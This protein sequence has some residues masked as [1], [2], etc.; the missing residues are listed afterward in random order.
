M[1]VC[2]TGPGGPG[3]SPSLVTAS[4][5]PPPG[6]VRRTGGGYSQKV[7]NFVIGLFA[8]QLLGGAYLFGYTLSAGRRDSTAHATRLPSAV[9][10]SHMLLGG[11]STA[12]WIGWVVSDER[13]FAWASFVSVALGVLLGTVMGLRTVT[14]PP[15]VDVP[16]NP[17]PRTPPDPADVRV[18][19]K[20]IPGVALLGHGGLGVTLLLL[21]LLIA[22]DVLS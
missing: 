11:F 17:V 16:Q 8:V 10:F 7:S 6:G 15:V 5:E 2:D 12:T 9:V 19:E 1:R 13:G 22:L 4:D 20:Q 3:R 14:K 21:T 18:A